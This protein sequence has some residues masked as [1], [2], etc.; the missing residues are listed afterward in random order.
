[1]N[2]LKDLA[3]KN[4]SYRRF[5]ESA[6]IPL[7][8]LRGLIDLACVVPS[9]ANRQPLRYRLVYEPSDCAAVF[10]TL[11][12]AAALPE[13]PGPAEGERPS[14]YILV[15]DDKSIPGNHDIDVGIAAQTILLGAA[16]LG[17]G[18]CM[19]ASVRRPELLAQ[20]SLSPDAYALPLV[21]ALGK[22]AE[23]VRLVPVPSS[24]VTTYYRDGSGVHYVPK[25]SV[26][27]ATV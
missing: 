25:R 9:A 5:D 14:A 19:L 24:G 21:I 17:Y 2:M 13:W 26:E 7:D 3:L 11:A 1:M 16:E 23:D 27:E 6:R 18:G 22:P 10:E 4:R 12:W 8:V 20:Q 15:L